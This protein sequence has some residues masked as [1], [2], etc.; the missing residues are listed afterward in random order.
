V[1]AAADGDWVQLAPGVHDGP[2]N[3]DL[4][5]DGVS[6][7]IRSTHGAAVTA[8]DAEG[9]GRILTVTGDGPTTTVV[10]VRDLTLKGGAATEGG[11]L[12]VESAAL[13]LE[14]CIVAGS[15]ASVRGGAIAASD[16]LLTVSASTLDGNAA[17][18][19]GGIALVGGA[20]AVIERTIVSFC[21]TGEAVA[22]DATSSAWLA[23]SD[24]FGNA[25]GDWV[26]AIAGQLA[27]RDNLAADPL[28]CDAPAG[29]WSLA[30]DSPCAP[31]QAPGSCG[32]IGALPVGCGTVG[33]AGDPALPSPDPAWR[34]FPNPLRAGATLH[35]LGPG[36]VGWLE[37]YDVQGRLVMR[38][39]SD[40]AS[41]PPGGGPAWTATGHAG[42]LPA[43]VYLVRAGGA[44]W[45]ASKKIVVVP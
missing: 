32:G 3:R 12:R 24:L 19:G 11:A 4:T 28:Y 39:S 5:I 21:T 2:G 7:E 42:P 35:H 40:R 34:C 6:L 26:G 8:V 36:P 17:P 16:A 37:V 23:C 41:S 1:A 29:V 18:T 13:E 45:S 22:V 25:G 20:T 9:L 10:A 15:D 43:G 14:G 38:R 31:G 30:L 33:L 44:G 27:E